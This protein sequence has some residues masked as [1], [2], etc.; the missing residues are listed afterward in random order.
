MSRSL[1]DY[2]ILACKGITMGFANVMPG[3]SGGT[4]AFISGIYEELIE[5]INALNFNNLKGLFKHGPKFFWNSIHGSFI[6]TLILSVLIG[7]YILVKL[8]SYL[9]LKFP[10]PIWSFF[11]GLILASS[12]Y[13]AIKINSQELKIKSILDNK[14]RNFKIVVF[15]ILGFVIAY[16][17]AIFTPVANSKAPEWY[18]ALGGA[19]AIS[20]LILPRISGSLIL[21]LMGEYQFILSAVDNLK[22]NFLLYFALGTVLGLILFTNALTWLLKKYYNYTI[23]FLVGV[24]L[25]SL[26]KVWPWKHTLLSHTN[27]FAQII[28]DKQENVLPFLYYDLTGKDPQF[29]YAILMAITG[30]LVVYLMESA[31]TKEK[32]AKET[33]Q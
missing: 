16:F 29:L 27:Q 21:L 25:G 18:V 5:S 4:I 32:L 22:M 10:I 13:L 30:F 1:K 7:I 14:S 6:T 9:L 11:L 2:F 26:N 20:A 17:S 31:Y 33:I 19:L 15:F 24:M 3:I 8:L 12:I 23:G 28:P